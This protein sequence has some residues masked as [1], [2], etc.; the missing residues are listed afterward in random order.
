MNVPGVR[1]LLATLTMITLG[2]TAVA[3]DAK[4]ASQPAAV[5]LYSIENTIESMQ[6]EHKDWATAVVR[7]DE[8]A[9]ETHEKAL[10]EAM[11]LD[12][13]R[14]EEQVRQ[15]ATEV[16][17]SQDSVVNSTSVKTDTQLRFERALSTLKTKHL[18]SRSLERTD[19]FSNKYRLLGDYIY[20]LRRE[21]GMKPPELAA[22]PGEPRQGNTMTQGTTTE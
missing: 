9:A 22:V 4:D 17:L 18:L 15:L 11:W 19:A 13:R 16:T 7:G 10:Y 8:N 6:Q 5:P 12:L 2:G 3:G 1:V 20:L 21:L 14:T